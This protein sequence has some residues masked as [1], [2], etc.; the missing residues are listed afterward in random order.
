MNI[1]SPDTI[2]SC[3]GCQMCAAV[4]SKGAITVRL[5][6]D[7]FYRPILDE[8]KCVDC[9]LCT[10]VCYKY[11]DEVLETSAFVDKPLYAASSNNN[12]T[13]KEVTSGGVADILAQKFIHSGYKCVGVVYDY[14]KDI[15]CHRIA[16]TENETIAF[17]GSKYIQSFTFDAFKEVVRNTR[18][19]KYAVFG[20]PCQVYA[21]DRYLRRIKVRDNF[22]LIDM[23]CHGCPS[24]N[25]WTKYQKELKAKTEAS[26]FDNVNFRSKVRGW[27]NFYV[28]VVV[29]AGVKY[30]FRNNS[31][32]RLFFSDAVLNDSCYDCRLRSTL[33]Y[34]DIRLG[35]FWG[36]QYVFNHRG[37]SAV[38]VCSERG[39]QL[40]ESIKSSIECTEQKYELFLPYQSWGKTYK[41]NDQLS[42]A[43]FESLRDEKKPLKDAVEILY[44][45]KSMKGKI[46]WCAKSVTNYL[47]NCFVSLL[48]WTYYA[49]KQ[50]IHRTKK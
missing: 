19:E 48:K 23:Y 30:W 1:L 44:R 6:R 21:L 37:M 41:K 11:D 16:T 27:G 31:F 34:T 49:L 42:R 4:C 15:A 29:V 10:K 18:K 45:N 20:L 26:T 36:D 32:Y 40:F 38:S 13:L 9:G 22:V 7:G 8:E 17:R 43:L 47:P 33:E 3:T 35:D 28:V 5:D 46:M 25:I 12:S 2:H 14:D 24:M 50:G 39:K